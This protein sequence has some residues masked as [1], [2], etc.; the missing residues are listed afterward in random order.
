MNFDQGFRF[1]CASCQYS[2]NLASQ[3]ISP[4]YC[5]IPCASPNQAAD[6]HHSNIAPHDSPC[7]SEPTTTYLFKMTHARHF[8]CTLLHAS[9]SIHSLVGPKHQ[10]YTILWWRKGRLQKCWNAHAC[11]CRPNSCMC[12][13]I[14][15]GQQGT[16]AVASRWGQVR[17]HRFCPCSWAWLAPQ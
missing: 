8:G 16:P 5:T 6:S 3:K 10:P 11:D 7:M 1:D 2:W 4:R 17:A 14:W 12:L 9:A 15:S 13:I